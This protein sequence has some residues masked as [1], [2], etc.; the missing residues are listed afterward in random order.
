MRTTR[1]DRTLAR[2][3]LGRAGLKSVLVLEGTVYHTFDC[4]VDRNGLGEGEGDSPDLSDDIYFIGS[5]YLSKAPPLSA[6]HWALTDI[7][8][9]SCPEHDPTYDF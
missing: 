3:F 7:T 2:C 1:G 9:T 4:G 6:C 8:Q 5:N